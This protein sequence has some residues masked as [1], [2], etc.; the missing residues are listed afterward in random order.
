MR[1]EKNAP[2]DVL[3]PW[4]KAQEIASRMVADADATLSELR[5][6]V[7]QHALLDDT[8]RLCASISKAMIF[9]L[10]KNQ[11]KAFSRLVNG[12]PYETLTA[13][14][15]NPPLVRMATWRLLHKVPS[16]VMLDP[17]HFH[18]RGPGGRSVYD[19]AAQN[20]C[21]RHIPVVMFSPDHLRRGIGGPGIFGRTDADSLLTAI[22]RYYSNFRYFSDLPKNSIRVLMESVDDDDFRSSHNATELFLEGFKLSSRTSFADAKD[23]ECHTFLSNY[24]LLRTQAGLTESRAP[25]DTDGH[26]GN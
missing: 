3:S 7:A 6:R 4:P 1:F 5:D 22:L 25:L 17:A 20:G 2:F 13:S 18:A 9:L 24:D 11:Q 12:L 15:P 8:P 19:A 21:I 23:L 10:R 14:N 26:H 16:D